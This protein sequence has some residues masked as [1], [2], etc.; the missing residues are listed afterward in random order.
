MAQEVL[1]LQ[2]V[3]HVHLP[4]VCEP[5]AAA[6]VTGLRAD[7]ILQQVFVATHKRGVK[8][9]TELPSVYLKCVFKQQHLATEVHWRDRK[10]LI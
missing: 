10:G 6:G 2:V 9:C 3:L 1:A 5:T 4:P 7:H 8:A